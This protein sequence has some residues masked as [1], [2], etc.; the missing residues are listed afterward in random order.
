MHLGR[1]LPL[2][3]LAAAAYGGLQDTAPRAGLLSLHARVQ[4]VTPDAWEDKA[5]AQVWGPRLAAYIVP[6]DAVATFTLGR[7]PRQGAERTAILSLARRLLAALGGTARRSN[8]VF[9]EFSDL[10]NPVMVRAASASGRFVIRWD[11]RATL[12][13]PIEPVKVGEEEARL[14]LA[15]RYDAWFG[16][17]DAEGFRRWAG[18]SASDA[19]VSWASIDHVD[20]REHTPISGVRLLPYGDPFMFDRP[21]VQPVAREVPGVLLVDGL[22]AGTWARRQAKVTLRPNRSMSRTD[23][24]RLEEA[25]LSLAGPL[26]R[27]VDLTIA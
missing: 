27:P 25:A 26:G 12:I 21:P 20:T 4:D 10:P 3:R 15:R 17:S 24:D 7:L 19:A 9:R 11:A 23:R 14:G 1:R 5:L 13:V 6:A 18:V 8:D 16:P 22:I 2:G